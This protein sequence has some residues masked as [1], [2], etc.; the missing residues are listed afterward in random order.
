MYVTE[1][2]AAGGWV[3]DFAPVIFGAGAAIVLPM[4]AVVVMQGRKITNL[5]SKLE[6]LRAERNE[7]ME[8]KLLHIESRLDEHE[9]AKHE[10]IDIERRLEQRH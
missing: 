9:R 3:E 2:V 4:A 10:A 6:E 7:A 5:Q 8:Q 1:L